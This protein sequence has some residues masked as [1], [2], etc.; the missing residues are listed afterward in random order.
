MTGYF[1]CFSAS[2]EQLIWL[3]RDVWEVWDV[4]T[5]ENNKL[6]VFTDLDSSTFIRFS[7]TSPLLSLHLLS[8]NKDFSSVPSAGD[9]LSVDHLLPV[10][11]TWPLRESSADFSARLH[12][13]ES[14]KWTSYI[15]LMI[16]L[17][18]WVYL[19]IKQLFFVK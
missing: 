10:Y 18:S 14:L 5:W 15:L 12:V 4:H 17:Y 2:E 19:D 3:K 11:I 7:D 6:F 8:L 16:I 13:L 9:D 1:L